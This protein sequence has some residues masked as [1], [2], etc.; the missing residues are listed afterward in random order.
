MREFIS[1]E[2]TWIVLI[3]ALVA[4]IILAL[5]LHRKYPRDLVSKTRRKPLRQS[6]IQQYGTP[7]KNSPH[8]SVTCYPCQNNQ[9]ENQGAHL[10]PNAQHQE[11]ETSKKEHEPNQE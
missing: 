11:I 5:L 7:S 9:G 8:Q 3:L 2:N 4:G 6:P 10:Q 1:P